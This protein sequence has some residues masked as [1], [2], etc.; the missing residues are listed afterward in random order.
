MN[1]VRAV[2]IDL[3]DTLW[4]IAPVI[5]QAEKR[6]YDLLAENCPAVAKS[7]S[8]DELREVRAQ[9]EIDFPE[10]KHDL[11]TMRKLTLERVLLEC[12][13]D[14]SHVEPVFEEFMQARNDVALF[15]DVIPS[16]KQLSK[17][18]PL[19]SI[20][21]GNADLNRIGLRSFFSACVSAREVGVA[22]PHPRVFLTAC[23]LAGYPPK[24]VIHI[25][26]HP[27]QDILGAAE[28]GMKTIWMNREGH[29][30]DHAH[31]PDAEVCSL[32][33]ATKLLVS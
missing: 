12:G 24:Y 14:T 6:M 20:S 2:T 1:S 13:Y 18:F 15:P 32:S 17:R 16:L 11:T 4:A 5:V 7:Y 27:H 21:N 29:I 19:V 30:W 31:Q 23:D 10:L 25:G 3:D 33:D 22:K 9:V 8:V 28:V 26:D